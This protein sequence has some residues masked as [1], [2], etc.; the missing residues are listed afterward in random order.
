MA[1]TYPAYGPRP[2]TSSAQPAAPT[3]TYATPNYPARTLSS[4]SDAGESSAALPHK[5]PESD[6][7]PDIRVDVRAIMRTPSPTPSETTELTKKGLVDWEAMK[8]RSYWFRREWLCEYAVLHRVRA[9]I[10]RQ[11]TMLL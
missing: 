7:T 9:L 2:G 1:S 8:K 5:E 11:G 4:D 6:K 3:P 10:P